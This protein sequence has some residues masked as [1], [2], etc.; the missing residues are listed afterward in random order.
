MYCGVPSESPVCV[1]RAPPAFEI[2]NAIPKSA[3]SGCP[4]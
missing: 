3:T 2:A 1:I 4:S